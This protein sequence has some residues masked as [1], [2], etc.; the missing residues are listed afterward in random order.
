MAGLMNIKKIKNRFESRQAKNR[1]PLSLLCLTLGAFAIGMTE[2]IIMGL[3]PNV[4]SDLGVSI[5]QAGQLITSYALGAMRL[6]LPS[7]RP[8]LPC[9]PTSCRRKSCWSS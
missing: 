5:P 3:L 4:A 8:S 7:V 9:S 2:F 1:F 6:V